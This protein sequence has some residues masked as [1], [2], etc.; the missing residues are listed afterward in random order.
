MEMKKDLIYE[1]KGKKIYSVQGHPDQVILFFKDDL[2]AYQGRKQSSFPKKG[3]ICKTISSLI[4]QYL[5][6]EGMPVHWI[7][8]LSPLESLCLKVDIFPL[9]VVIR[10]RLAG[11]TAQRL[12][13]KEG[14]SILQAPL[15]E[16]YYKKDELDDPFISE[17][18][19]IKLSLIKNV[20]F[21]EGIKKQA[22][23]INE[24][25][26]FFFSEAGLELVDFK[27]E[28]GEAEDKIFLSDEISPDSCRLWDQKTEYRLDKDRFRRGW[29][30]VEES[31]QKIQDKLLKKWG[32][33]FD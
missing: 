19:I 24:K 6:Q 10:N 29:G 20:A 5:K 32:E 7:K 17:D 12:G 31:Y 28:F 26:K 25:L 30:G 18:Q 14:Q 27:M 2:T 15:L 13:L 3:E 33:S 9:E 11:S 1:G 23:K 21:L 16:F 22:L 8:D 4:F